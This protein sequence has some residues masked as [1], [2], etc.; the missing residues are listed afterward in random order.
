V[1][2]RSYRSEFGRADGAVAGCGALMRGALRAG[3]AEKAQAEA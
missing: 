3:M 1:N 2:C